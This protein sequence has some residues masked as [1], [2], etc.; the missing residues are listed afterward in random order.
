MSPERIDAET[1]AAFLDGK[2]DATERARVERILA[3]HPEEYDVF[4]D[5]AHVRDRLGENVRSIGSARRRRWL[6]AV[7]AT[8]AAG[9]ALALV[10][11]RLRSPL[12]PRDLAGR[13]NLVAVPG[14]GSL[15]MRL[16]ASWDQPGW[17][18][19]RG[20]GGGPDVT[21][22]ARA[23]RV[24][25]RATDVEIAFGAQDTSALRLVGA[26]LIGLLGGIDGGGPVAALYQRVLDQGSAASVGDRK[27]AIDALAAMLDNSPWYQLGAWVEAARVALLSDQPR[28]LTD[29]RAE[30]SGLVSKLN[31]PP[32]S[33]GAD[34][35]VLLHQLDSGLAKGQALQMSA[36]IRRIIVA[37]GG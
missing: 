17:S 23:F 3:E 22:R 10:L 32:A 9:I 20:P 31:A 14:N 26:D 30:L 13:L 35:M 1:L 34:L 27:A 18:V 33:A 19:T 21:E 15:A 8:L 6:L 29:H 11:P 24:G 12:S 4:S 36:V 37:A 5:A 28:F 7:P 16:G 25:A 2:L